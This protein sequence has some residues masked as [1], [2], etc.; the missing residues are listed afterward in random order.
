[1]TTAQRIIKYVSLA[2]AVSIIVAIF[3]S[4]YY[5]VPTVASFLNFDDDEKVSEELKE[6]TIDNKEVSYLDIEVAFSKLIIKEGEELQAET[7][8]PYINIKQKDNR[9]EI[10]E[11]N[12]HNLSSNKRLLEITI[13]KDIVFDNVSIETGA[14]K[15]D[16]ESINAKTL[17]LE[18]GL[19][20]TVIKEANVSEN[21]KL[22]SGVGS[23]VVK[24]GSLNNLD[25]EMGV[26]SVKLSTN[27]LGNCKIEAGVGAVNLNIP[28]TIDNYTFRVEKGIGAVKI[29]SVSLSDGAIYGAGTNKIS[30]EGGIGSIN[31]KLEGVNVPVTETPIEEIPE[32][33][34]FR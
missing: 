32:S 23:F 24:S 34:G 3:S 27:I 6:L 28:N 29:D 15:V 22:Q 16:I 11:E 31:V 10:T 8:N 1:M 13:P 5:V 21:T 19:G 17:E 25:A 7:N 14:G 26:G 30:L 9:L 12:H 18:L 20:A 4:I 2:F 33:E